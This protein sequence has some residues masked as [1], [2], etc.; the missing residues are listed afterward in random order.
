MYPNLRIFH[1]VHAVKR[2]GRYEE[3]ISTTDV[4]TGE[5]GKRKR[6]GR[7]KRKRIQSWKK[8]T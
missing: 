1:G 2:L 8:S 4:T 3:I 5:R 6:I 7:G